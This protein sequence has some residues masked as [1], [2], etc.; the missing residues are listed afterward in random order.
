[1]RL[2]CVLPLLQP[3]FYCD[4]ELTVSRLQTD[5]V[6]HCLAR[7][8][9]AWSSAG[10][11]A[12]RRV[13]ALLTPTCAA[14][15]SLICPARCRL[16]G[17]HQEGASLRHS[18]LTVLHAVDVWLQLPVRLLWPPFPIAAGIFFHLLLQILP[19]P[20]SQPKV[21]QHCNQCSA[22]R[23]TCIDCSASFDRRSVQVGWGCA[24]GQEGVWRPA[25]VPGKAVQQRLQVCGEVESC[26]SSRQC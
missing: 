10:D 3:W 20:A 16:R 8:R 26:A 17:H 22:S 11:E 14:P 5:G 23:F 18:D 13:K 12:W 7:Y 25:R 19:A 9:G 21:A 4:G 1:M 15:A 6:L 2:P 24:S